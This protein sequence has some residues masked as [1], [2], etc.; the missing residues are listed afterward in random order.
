MHGLS[1]C[2]AEASRMVGPT[3]VW[4]PSGRLKELREVVLTTESEEQSQLDALHEE[5]VRMHERAQQAEADVAALGRRLSEGPSRVQ[6]LEERLLETKGQLSQA[7]S[8][9]EKLTFTLQ[10]A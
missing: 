7:V 1:S 10:Q 3:G 5:V 2:T 4:S 6:S 9:N 8:Q